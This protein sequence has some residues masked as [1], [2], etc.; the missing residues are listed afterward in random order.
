MK[1][2]NDRKSELPCRS[3]YNR[4]Y[5]F[6]IWKTWLIVKRTLR[7]LISTATILRWTYGQ[8]SFNPVIYNPWLD[9]TCIC[10]PYM[11]FKRV[12]TCVGCYILLIPLSTIFLIWWFFVSHKYQVSFY[13]QKHAYSIYMYTYYHWFV[14]L[15][16]YPQYQI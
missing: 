4:Y 2:N 3:G 5:N 1:N 13:K 12:K 11:F 15:S 16:I 9:G 8:L 6:F 14:H 7:K 10:S